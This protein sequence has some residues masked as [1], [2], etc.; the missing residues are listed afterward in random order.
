MQ[1]IILSGMNR[2]YG[3]K[4][5]VGN[6]YAKIDKSGMHF[7]ITT[8]EVKGFGHLSVIDMKAM[9]GLMKMESVILN[10]ETKDLPLFSGDFIKAMGKCTLLEEF[11]DTMIDPIP[12]ADITVYRGV[13]AKYAD[14]PLYST[15]PHWYD[16]IRYDFTLGAT[17]KSLNTRKEGITADYLAAYLKNAEH[18]PAADPAHKKEKTKAYV[19]GLLTNGGPAVNQFKKLFGEAATREI[20]EK[21]LFSCR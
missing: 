8:Y 2:L 21:Y 10:A 15:E 6:P 4:P 12:D 19:D 14:L 9:L 16:S 3:L 1:E 7:T 17:D 20:F 11:Y 5:I 13:K 18:A